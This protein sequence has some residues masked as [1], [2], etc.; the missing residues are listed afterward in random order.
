MH[1]SHSSAKPAIARKRSFATHRLHASL[2]TAKTTNTKGVWAKNAKAAT[3]IRRGRTSSSTMTK[4]GSHS[5]GNMQTRNATHATQTTGTRTRHAHVFPAIAKTT[6]TRGVSVKS[7]NRATALTIGNRSL[8]TPNKPVTR[9]WANMPPQNAN[10]ATA[11]RFTPKNC[12]RV[13]TRVM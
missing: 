3:T 9:Y 7:A 8:T 6:P 13:A 1:M 2:A 11:L 10:P 4:R 5:L 12:R